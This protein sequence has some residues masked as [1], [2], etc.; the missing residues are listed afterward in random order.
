MMVKPACAWTG[1]S[2]S[3]TKK[4]SSSGSSRR[5]GKNAIRGGEI[6]NLE[7]LAH[8]DPEPEAGLAWHD[9]HSID[10]QISL[11]EA[12]RVHQRKGTAHHL[13]LGLHFGNKKNGHT[14]PVIAHAQSVPG[15]ECSV[16]AS[17]ALERPP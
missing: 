7:I 12:C 10:E 17:R 4:A 8:V 16:R 2:D 6:D 9:R 11:F 13:E 5:N 15:T 1:R 14:H 3:A